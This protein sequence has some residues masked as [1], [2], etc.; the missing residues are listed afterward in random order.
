[1][2]QFFLLL[3]VLLLGG[4]TSS[5]WAQWYGVTYRPSGV[6]Y[7]VLRSAHFDLIY[8]Q[9]REA[10][11]RAT[12]ALLEAH[13]DSVR[14]LLGARH[15]FRMPVIINDYRDRGG[16]FVSALPFRQELDV[17]RLR[18]LS[19]APA[20]YSWLHA[21]APHELVHAVHAALNPGIGVG[22]GLRL[23]GPDW[24]RLLNMWVPAGFA[25]GVAVYYESRIEGG[26]GRLRFPFFNMEFRAAMAS[27]YP[28]RLAQLL[29]ASAYTWPFDRHYNGGG[30]L[31]QYLVENGQADFFRRT[32]RWFH[33]MPLTGFGVAF[34][35]GTGQF[36]ASLG[37]H[38]RKTMQEQ[39]QT[40][41]V[42]RAPFTEVQVVHS[43]RG[44]ILRRPYWLDNRTLVV[45]GLGY[46]ERPGYYQIDAETGHM[47]RLHTF[48]TT[49][50]Y[51]YAPTA[52]Q[53]ALLVARYVP[54]PLLSGRLT[55][56]VY[57]IAQSGKLQRLTHGGRVYAPV[58]APDGSIWALQNQ[59]I[60]NRWVRIGTDGR[61]TPVL[62]LEDAFF[63]QL[64]PSPQGDRV[65]VVL[66][67]NGRQGLFE[68]QFASD[69][70]ATLR[71]WLAFRHGAIYDVSWS[72]DGRWLLLTADPDSVPNIY[73]L[74]VASGRV[75]RL[76]NVAF[77]ALEP[78]LSPDGRH[79]AFIHYRHERYEL[80]R[81]P[82]QPEA[83][84]EIPPTELAPQALQ[85]VAV[86]KADPVAF[87]GPPRPYRPGRYLWRPRLTYLLGNLPQ[88]DPDG[89]GEGLDWALGLGLEGTDPLQ[90]WVYMAQGFYR[91]DRLWGSLWLN[92]GGW[93]FRP[94]LYLY[95][96]PASALVR[97]GDG[98]IRRVGRERR[99]VAFSANLPVLLESN[100]YSSWLLLTLIGRSEAE[101][102]FWHRQPGHPTLLSDTRQTVEPIVTV[103]YRLQQNLRDLMPNQGVSWTTRALWDLQRSTLARRESYRSSLYLYLPLL[104]R[105]NVGLRLDAGLLWQNRGNVF[106]LTTF[107]PRGWED[108]FL[109]PGTFGR[110]GALALVPL[111]FIDNGLVILPLYVEALYLYGFAETVRNLD[112]EGPEVHDLSAIGGG[113]GLQLRIFSHL[114]LNLR[115]GMAYRLRDGKWQI[116][117]R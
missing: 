5:A 56:E 69:G 88:G 59:G 20:A 112:S 77:G 53:K 99:G 30:H 110:L 63:V 66:N 109:G 67:R 75:R 32:T 18:G 7:Q 87:E 100:V 23:L 48:A 61:I 93:P 14:A 82:F 12:A 68:A 46:Q 54:D 85:A 62:V 115:A 36:P 74:E 40:E 64:A 76:T 17:A 92:Y 21:V 27:K 94:G 45:Y 2:L 37:R 117:W 101:R 97:F 95:D 8:Q 25:E 108:V 15:N 102:Y 81:I 44:L 52:D 33:R 49:E 10:E 65:A 39:V 57:R 38:F 104:A 28:W 73:T 116:V 60:Y 90:R 80:V 78:A 114:R 13:Y 6:H 79:L 29:E 55:A 83:A 107:L 31:H 86:H 41:L 22:W 71:P 51:L 26:A 84:P 3:V 11:A 113:A 91:Q 50:D 4:T 16:G 47:T 98:V 106:D 24:S 89:Y 9:G 72:N 34:W 103:A 111:K 70:R 105:Y 42:R 58:E 1:M 96:L 19:V 35:Y 43:E